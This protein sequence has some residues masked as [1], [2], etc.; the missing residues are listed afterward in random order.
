MVLCRTANRSLGLFLRPPITLAKTHQRAHQ[1]HAPPLTAQ[2]HQPQH[3]PNTPLHHRGQPQP[4]ATTTT[5]LAQPPPPLQS[6]NEHPPLELALVRDRS[7]FGPDA[8]S[9]RSS[10]PTPQD[11]LTETPRG[12]TLSG[13]RDCPTRVVS[14]RFISEAGQLGSSGSFN[15]R[16]VGLFD[17]CRFHPNT[18]PSPQ[19]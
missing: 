18:P 11:P 1:R 8:A 4:H 3:R 16:R 9:C 6:T 12:P 2:K 5:Q 14:P 17:H 19:C 13:W 15:L 10:D 7:R